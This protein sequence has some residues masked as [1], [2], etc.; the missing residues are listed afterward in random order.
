MPGSPGHRGRCPAGDAL[1]SAFP[2]QGAGATGP[3]WGEHPSPPPLSSPYR[4]GGPMRQWALLPLGLWREDPAGRCCWGTAGTPQ[5]APLYAKMEEEEGPRVA[6]GWHMPP[7]GAHKAPRTS[8]AHPRGLGPPRTPGLPRPTASQGS[9]AWIRFCPGYQHSVC[10][11]LPPGGGGPRSRSCGRLPWS[12]RA[13]GPCASRRLPVLA[14]A[15]TPGAPAGRAPVGR[16][17]SC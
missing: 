5:P 13:S 7:R 15:S 6:R 8:T 10:C 4:L 11:P 9:R 1:A 12:R 16:C 14:Q 3:A 17:P 2:E